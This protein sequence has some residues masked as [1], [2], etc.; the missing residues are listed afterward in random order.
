MSSREEYVQKMHE[1]LDKLNAE[2]DSLTKRAENTGADL[3]EEL[4]G[5]RGKQDEAGTRLAALR[6]AGEGAWEDLKAGVELAKDAIGE[7][8]ESAKSRF[9]K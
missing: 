8:V 5:L 2:I 1:L 9:Q 4:A 3:R 6:T 7:A